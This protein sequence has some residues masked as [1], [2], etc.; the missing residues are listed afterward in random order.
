M[1]TSLNIGN[2]KYIETNGYR[3]DRSYPTRSG[4]LFLSID[5][6]INREK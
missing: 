3:R 5:I 6:D 1:A 2:F 4:E